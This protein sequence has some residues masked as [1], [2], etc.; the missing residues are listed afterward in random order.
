LILRETQC[1]GM[2]DLRTTLV[3]HAKNADT[4]ITR[5]LGSQ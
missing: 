4:I 5:G 2:S 1:E 3:K